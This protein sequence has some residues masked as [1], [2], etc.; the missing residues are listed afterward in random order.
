MNL[1][2][3]LS[4]I[5]AVLTVVY[6]PYKALGV[7]ITYSVG[8]T[9]PHHC[10]GAPTAKSPIEACRKAWP[11]GSYSISLSGG[12]GNLGDDEYVSG[13]TCTVNRNGDILVIKLCEHVPLEDNLGDDCDL[14][15]FG[16]PVNAATGNKFQKEV[17]YKSKRFG[18][19]VSRYYNSNLGHRWQFSY[20]DS[21]EISPSTPNIITYSRPDGLAIR[22]E[23]IDGVWESRRNNFSLNAVG[24]LWRLREYGGKTKLFDDNGK[25]IEIV[26]QNGSI[27]TLLYSDSNTPKNTAP[28]PGYL[29]GVES[30][31]GKSITYSYDG[32]G[33]V[34]HVI[35]LSGLEIHYVYDSEGRLVEVTYPDETSKQYVYNEPEN[36]L[37]TD[38][39]S[40]L[41][42]IIGRSGHRISTF[43]YD[44]D[45][46]TVYTSGQGESGSFEFDYSLG[47]TVV[48]RPNGSTNTVDFELVN[49][50]ILIA[51][52]TY[53]GGHSCSSSTNET[54]YRT[55]TPEGWLKTETDLNGNTTEYSYDQKGRV[56]T[57][58]VAKGTPEENIIE[59]IWHPTLD[60]K[61]RIINGPKTTVYTYDNAGRVL[62]ERTERTQ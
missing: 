8:Y 49:G 56:T 3:V 39:P 13:P 16:N 22:F 25:L 32:E 18:L 57:K 38:R 42:G 19:S 2:L 6:T 10:R 43:K 58:I 28:G 27:K 47:R 1:K 50:R 60:R 21:L 30:F 41:T 11:G 62:S 5:L 4:L 34:S 51:S 14:P 53:P 17:D 29:I 20:T 40:A 7:E 54:M 15:Y 31:S 35:D 24:D 23:N 33:R 46:R 37:S 55:F 9:S 45:G 59:T 26:S 12:K 48:T 61:I 52:Q 36:T 44:S